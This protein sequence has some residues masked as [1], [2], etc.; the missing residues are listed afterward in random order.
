M[1]MRHCMN[2][3]TA[4]LAISSSTASSF[5]GK[6]HVAVQCSPCSAHQ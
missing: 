2:S 6:G 5:G 3:I 4:A 1:L